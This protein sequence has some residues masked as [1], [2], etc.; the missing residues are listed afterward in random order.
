MNPSA[1]PSRYRLRVKQ[2]IVAIDRAL[3]CGITPANRHF[4]L[5]RKAVRRW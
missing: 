1:V 4:G 5:D 3:A 2:R